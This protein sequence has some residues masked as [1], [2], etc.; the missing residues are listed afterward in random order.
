MRWSSLAIGMVVAC[1]AVVPA[2]ATPCLVEDGCNPPRVLGGPVLP[3]APTLY[4]TA[5]CDRWDLDDVEVR[6]DGVPTPARIAVVAGDGWVQRRIDVDARRGAVEVQISGDLRYRGR[7]VEGIVPSSTVRGVV[8]VTDHADVVGYRVAFAERGVAYW[9]GGRVEVSPE[10]CGPEVAVAA[11][12]AVAAIDAHL[13]DG[14]VTHHRV[15]I[16]RSP[17]TPAG[18]APIGA[19]VAATAGGLVLA[20]IAVLARRRWRAAAPISSS[21][22]PRRR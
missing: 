8:P 11:D 10:I 16:P 17:L 20:A 13:T 22:R 4:V 21:A 7:I 14:R 19:A 15:V 3:P 12:V 18:P 1:G 2:A 5:G 9:T 6:I